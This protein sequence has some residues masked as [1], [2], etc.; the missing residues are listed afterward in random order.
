MIELCC[1]ASLAG[2]LGHV[3]RAGTVLMLPA[4]LDQ[5]GAAVPA[6]AA[7][8][9]AVLRDRAEE[10]VRIWTDRTPA[11]QCALRFAACLLTGTPDRAVLQLI[12]PDWE[13]RPDDM[14]LEHGS[15]GDLAPEE[16]AAHLSEAVE[17]PPLR[18]RMLAGEWRTLADENA[19]LRAMVNGRLISVE[20]GFYDPLILR[21][22]PEGPVQVANLI[23]NVLGRQRPGVDDRLLAGRI[24]AMLDAG[25]LRMVREDPDRFY[26]SVVERA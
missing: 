4:D 25:A 15:W 1:N 20:A 24:R 7:P 22:L 13:A 6:P 17:L 18:V 9:W 19:P 2:S 16:L 3:P 5:D 11:S 12:L 23:G 8:Q 21:E 14:I 26:A 10:P